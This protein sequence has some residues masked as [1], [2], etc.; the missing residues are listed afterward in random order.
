M[1]GS[2]TCTSFLTTTTECSRLFSG[3][4]CF[5]GFSLSLSLSRPNHLGDTL[6]QHVCTAAAAAAAAAAANCCVHLIN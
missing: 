4:R 1:R 3:C 2:N 6:F 5:Q